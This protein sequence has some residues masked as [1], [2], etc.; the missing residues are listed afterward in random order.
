[1]T[2]LEILSVKETIKG[3]VNSQPLPKEVVR[4]V[5]KEVLEEVTKEAY[6]EV[7]KEFIERNNEDGRQI[8]ADS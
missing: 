5:L 2:S 8:S 1:M 4:L 7:Q 3:Y 6:E